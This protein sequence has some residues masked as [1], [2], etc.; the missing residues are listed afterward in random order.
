MTKHPWNVSLRYTFF[1]WIFFHFFY[2]IHILTGDICCY[3]QSKL[4]A[5]A[6]TSAAHATIEESIPVVDKVVDDGWGSPRAN[7]TTSSGII[8]FFFITTFTME[9]FL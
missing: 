9:L 5:H 7:L 8:H 2:C 4:A 3:F 1:I 6:S